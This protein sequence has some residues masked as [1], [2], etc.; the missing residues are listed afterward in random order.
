MLVGAK[1]LCGGLPT[2]SKLKQ[3]FFIEP[4][5]FDNV[6][7]N[8]AIWWVC[9]GVT[10]SLQFTLPRLRY[11]DI[12]IF[13]CNSLCC[14]LSL[15]HEL[16]RREEIF[17]PVLAVK[18]FKTEQEALKL[19]NDS[20]YGL[21]GAVI[22]KDQDRC[23]RVVRALR[24]G[25]VWVNCSQVGILKHIKLTTARFFLFFFFFCVNLNCLHRVLPKRKLR[26]LLPEHFGFLFFFLS[27]SLTNVFPTA[28]YF[29]SSA[30]GRHETKRF[31]PWIRTLGVNELPRA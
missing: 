2:D 30:V 27:L 14:R 5:V 19:A 17:G 8:M 28:A 22:S 9:F 24:C 29:G 10:Q 12:Q 11:L 4:V 31:R 20:T 3:G 7:P 6:Q 23:K 21:A 16:Y 1:L 18:S 25:I 26:N 15:I 13:R